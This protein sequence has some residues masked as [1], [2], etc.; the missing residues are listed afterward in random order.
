MNSAEAAT[1]N[2]RNFTKNG[3]VAAVPAANRKGR[4]GRQQLDAKTTL[5]RAATLAKAVLFD[6]DLLFC[7]SSVIVGVIVLSCSAESSKDLAFLGSRDV[8]S[9]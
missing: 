6:L 8:F 7:P 1:K 2:G 4:R 9:P 3:E 5:P